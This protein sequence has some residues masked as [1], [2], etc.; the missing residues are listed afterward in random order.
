M[1][2]WLL[3]A[4]YKDPKLSI[5]EVGDSPP[6]TAE[7]GFVLA[8]LHM[9]SS[10]PVKQELMDSAQGTV[11]GVLFYFLPHSNVYGCYANCVAKYGAVEVQCTK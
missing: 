3:E 1:L 2:R 9:S 11:A 8:T 6:C 7:V 4:M 10:L 5:L